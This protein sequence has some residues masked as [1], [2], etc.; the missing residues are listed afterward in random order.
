M[1]S[2]CYGEVPGRNLTM[3]SDYY[4]DRFQVNLLVVSDRYGEVPGR[5]LTM[6]SD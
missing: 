6:G 1:G 4:G 5:N 3:G 2:D